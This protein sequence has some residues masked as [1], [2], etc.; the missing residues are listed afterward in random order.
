MATKDGILHYGDV[1]GASGI[2]DKSAGAHPHSDFKQK[3]SENTYVLFI[4]QLSF[5]QTMKISMSIAQAD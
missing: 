2:T 3:T 5:T 1:V 4:P